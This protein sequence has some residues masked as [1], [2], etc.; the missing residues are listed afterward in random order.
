VC[1]IETSI[2]GA[3]YIY[4]YI[5][6]YIYDI[7]SL[8]VNDLNKIQTQYIL[9]WLRQWLFVVLVGSVTFQ[10]S[11]YNQLSIV[12][13]VNRVYWTHILMHLLYV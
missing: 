10:I 4:I 7:S 13:W 1:D 2:I 9:Q 8:R 3:P 6:I 11:H 12:N 5:Y